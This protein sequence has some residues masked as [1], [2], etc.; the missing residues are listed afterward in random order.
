[1]RKRKGETNQDQHAK[2]VRKF[3]QDELLEISE[4][5]REVADLNA[6]I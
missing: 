3:G 6:E 1:M 2:R 4:Y 5:E